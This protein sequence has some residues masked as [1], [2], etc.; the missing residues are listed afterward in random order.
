MRSR[1]EIR[2]HRARDRIAA[3][4]ADIVHRQ[5]AF[6]HFAKRL[7][8]DL[9][10]AL[11][12]FVLEGCVSFSE[13]SMEELQHLSIPEDWTQPAPGV[14]GALRQTGLLFLARSGDDGLVYVPE[15]ARAAMAL[16]LEARMRKQCAT[17]DRDAASAL[18]ACAE[19]ERKR[20]AKE[21]VVCDCDHDVPW[22]IPS[23]LARLRRRTPGP[24]RVAEI[25]IRSE[26]A[27]RPLTRRI[28]I[29]YQ[30]TVGA[31][32]TVLQLALGSAQQ[33]GC[34]F[35]EPEE[36]RPF[37]RWLSPDDEYYAN[38]D[39]DE[40]ATSI[41]DALA[42]HGPALRYVPE[43]GSL[44][45]HRVRLVALHAPERVEAEPRIV[46]GTD[47]YEESPYGTAAHEL[48]ASLAE[49]NLLLERL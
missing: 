19:P 6:E 40:W 41:R 4:I 32:R 31:L 20:Q 5:Y 14:G 45:R 34:V 15:E 2:G 29:S 36:D 33:G 10:R 7:S 47:T 1:Y 3:R 26:D 38:G 49:A 9:L 18:W 37:R 24:D 28:L 22:V 42:A 23:R 8:P 39:R 21:A 43:P 12:R 17:S 44:P 27:R 25:E 13:L 35:V 46:G 11:A 16:V 30:R 48:E